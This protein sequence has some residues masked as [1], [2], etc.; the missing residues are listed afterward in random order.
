M[1]LSLTSPGIGLGLALVTILPAIA[2]TNSEP[3]FEGQTSR[4]Q[5]SAPVP[6][7]FARAAAAMN[8]SQIEASEIALNR[9]TET[10]IQAL[11]RDVLRDHQQAQKELFQAAKEQGISVMAIADSDRE[12]Q[13]DA[14]K[15]APDEQFG[16]TF[17]SLLAVA[18][19]DA[20]DLHTLY[21]DTGQ[22]G[23]LKVHAN[24]QLSTLRTHLIRAQ[25][26]AER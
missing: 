15:N 26:A 10:V 18:Q 11:A 22:K 19:Q 7:T 25:S 5:Q 21:G 12:A 13:V 8:R 6:E 2:Q 20:I 3:K 4:N 16:A 1:K 14:L 9:S 24:A 23:A 17:L